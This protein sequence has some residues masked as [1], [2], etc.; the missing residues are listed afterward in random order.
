MF[1]D[2][3]NSLATFQTMMNDIFHNLIADCIM[4]MHLDNILIFTQ[5]LEEYHKIVQRMLKILTKHKLFLY[6]EKCKFDK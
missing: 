3:T 2:I 5:T 1:F 6:P 4:I